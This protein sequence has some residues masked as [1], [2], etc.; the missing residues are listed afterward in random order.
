MK[1]LL[2]NV[3]TA[4]CKCGI[5]ALDGD[6]LDWPLEDRPVIYVAG[7]YSAC[8][9]H[10]VRNA[11]Q[12]YEELLAVGWIPLVPH[13][14]MLLDMLAPN[15]PDFWYSYDLALLARCDAMYVCSDILTRD[16]TGVDK[17]ITFC[18]T[19]DIPVYYE[20]IPAKDRYSR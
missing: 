15:T 16:S 19:H 2:Y 4:P 7:Y 9:T 17:E 13:A 18:L 6:P 1:E 11:V 20:V 8:P 5:L 3:P 14:S 10:G 12:A